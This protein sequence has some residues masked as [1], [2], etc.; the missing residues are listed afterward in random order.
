MVVNAT[1]SNRGYRVGPRSRGAASG[2]GC[3]PAEYMAKHGKPKTR[4]QQQLI[5]HRP[6]AQVTWS[7]R[8]GHR[9]V[10]VTRK[11]QVLQ[12]VKSRS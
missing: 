2:L 4:P 6:K 8:N 1:R 3:T 10:T 7:G 12:L 11:P 5:S 9:V